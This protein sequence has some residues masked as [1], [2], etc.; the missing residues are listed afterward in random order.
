M[1][2]VVVYSLRKFIHRLGWSPEFRMRTPVEA[3]ERAQTR[4]NEIRRAIMLGHLKSQSEVE[5]QANRVLREEGAHRICR[6]AAKRG[7]SDGPAFEIE[8]RPTEPL[9]RV[10]K[11]LH[12]HAYVGLA[13]GV[14]LYVHGG[15]TFESPMGAILNGLTLLIILT[16]VLGI[17]LFALGPRWMTRAER[18]MNFEEAFVLARSLKEK[19]KEAYAA[20]PENQVTEFRSAERSRSTSVVVQQTALMKIVELDPQSEKDLQDV[21]VLV[22]QRRRILQDLRQASRV[23][24]LINAWRL[25]HIPATILLM[26]FVAVHVF[27]VWWY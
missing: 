1:V 12:F 17:V 26:G 15:G 21:M 22:G 27:S 6:A 16:G 3:L 10:S 19:I 8:I 14:V 9:G 2:A 11:W 7:E 24:L 20:L 23:R 4:M 5:R 13:T 18:D 25:V